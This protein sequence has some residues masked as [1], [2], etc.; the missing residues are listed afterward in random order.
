LVAAV[1]RVVGTRRRI[2]LFTVGVLG[3]SVYFLPAV[4]GQVRIWLP[5]GGRAS[6][7]LPSGAF[8][9]MT[10]VMGVLVVGMEF[11]DR[12]PGRSNVP[13]PRR[14]SV[15][16]GM[17]V[18]VLAAV[19]FLL[20]MADLGSGV[21][22]ADK[23][24]IYETRNV[25]YYNLALYPAL[26]VSVYGAAVRSRILMGGAFFII[27]LDTL[28]V[29]NRTFLVIGVLSAAVVYARRLGPVRLFRMWRLVVP[30]LVFT[31]SVMGY[32]HVKDEI[33]R[34]DLA[35]AAQRVT[36]PGYIAYAVLTSEPFSTQAILAEVVRTDFR[37]SPSEYA[38]SWMMGIPFWSE[39]IGSA[40]RFS[41]QYQQSLFPG[42]GEI[43]VMADNFW[44][45]GF[46][47]GGWVGVGLHVLIYGVSVFLLNRAMSSRSRIV[48]AISAL[49]GV[50]VA[51]YIHRNDV[52]GMI[53]ALRRIALAFGM[54]WVLEACAR[55]LRVAV[56]TPTRV[57]P[58]AS[59]AA[60][61]GG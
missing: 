17:V 33:K 13:A 50:W 7:A 34:L 40:P 46:A 52:V 24:N 11:H 2:D 21:L 22:D 35:G 26:C 4:F 12:M 53:S 23:A 47:M 38:G 61:S 42:V 57:T 28:L 48:L 55:A 32:H 29:M 8:I 49:A 6:G 15:G 9:A 14:H 54:L 41:E 45:Q 56:R 10:A 43:G 20:F 44:A 60:G 31:W 27:L 18:L 19:A 37:V 30:G 51:F 1:V 5:G 36:E 58:Q 3:C 16:P 25:R 59:V 39:A